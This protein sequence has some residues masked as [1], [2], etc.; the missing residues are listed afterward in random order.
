MFG[1]E[2]ITNNNGWAMA[3]VGATIVFSGLVVLSFVISQIHKI[4]KLWDER[5]KLIERFKRAVPAADAE[6]AEAPVYSERH[7]PSVDELAGIYQP[8]VEQLE[9]PFKLS[10]LFEIANKNDV[11]H[12]H[13]SI[14]RLQEAELLVAEGDGTFSWKKP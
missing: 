14:Q 2:N 5:E 3:A 1:I 12:P 9:E 13:L 7:L 8:L 4:L 6:K 11:P 10:Q